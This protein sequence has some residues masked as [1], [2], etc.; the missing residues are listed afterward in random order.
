MARDGRYQARPR[1]R[2]AGAWWRRR[3]AP[4]SRPGRPAFPFPGVRCVFP[5]AWFGVSGTYVPVGPGDGGRDVGLLAT[6]GVTH[7]AYR[8]F[9]IA[10]GDVMDPVA[11]VEVYAIVRADR[12]LVTEGICRPVGLTGGDVVDPVTLVG[13][14]ALV[15]P[16]FAL[17]AARAVRGQDET[18][19]S[20]CCGKGRVPGLRVVLTIS[21]TLSCCSF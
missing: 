1:D 10:G 15:R 12:G 11:H 4:G 19:S 2:V 8:S 17:W 9:I 20:G 6:R 5:A 14:D 21:S 16:D 7:L 13:V 3:Q 18:R